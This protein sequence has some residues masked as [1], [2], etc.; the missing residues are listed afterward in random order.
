MNIDVKFSMNNL[1]LNLKTHQQTIHYYQIVFILET[2]GWLNIRKSV[3]TIHLFKELKENTHMIIS[4]DA[5]NAFN[6]IQHTFMIKVLV[7]LEIKGIC[8]NKIKAVYGK[9]IAKIK[10]NGDSI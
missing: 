9:P 3:N 5:E 1:K 4:L 2:L 7:R 10:L 6:K 8:L